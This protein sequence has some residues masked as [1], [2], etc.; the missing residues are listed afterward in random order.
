[1]EEP[2]KNVAGL[3]ESSVLRSR[4]IT[5]PLAGAATNSMVVALANVY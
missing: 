3:S 4:R 1:M 5:A 2:G